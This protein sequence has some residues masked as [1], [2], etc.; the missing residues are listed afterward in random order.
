MAAT[1]KTV[2]L[3]AFA[4]TI[5]QLATGKHA[6]SWKITYRDASGTI[7][8]GGILKLEAKAK[9]KAREIL[10][11]LSGDDLTL[12][13]EEADLIR[14]I[15]EKAV[16]PELLL[17]TVTSLAALKSLTVAA[18]VKTFLEREVEN[19]NY[20]YEQRKDYHRVLGELSTRFGLKNLGIITLEN[21]EKWADA[22][23]CGAKRYNNKRTILLSF[24]RWAVGRN[25]ASKNIAESLPRKRLTR[26]AA[27]EVLSPR[28]FAAILAKCPHNYIPW[29]ALSGF[30]GLRGV[31]IYGRVDDR[32]SGLKWEN[33]DWNRKLIVL[34]RHSA[35]QT[36]S[37]KTRIIPAC[38]ALL[39][40]LEPWQASTGLVFPPSTTLPHSGTNSITSQLAQH[41]PGGKW[42]SNALRASRASYRLAETQ[43]IAIVTLEMG[44]SKDMLLG[45]YLNPRF[46]D[47]AKIWFSLDRSTTS[48][49]RVQP[50]VVSFAV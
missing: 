25:H 38:D 5:T 45:T 40:W 50:E 6:G 9:T 8:T 43:S 22:W 48:Q 13:P 2:K 26:K 39:D 16:K 32:T 4:A 41:L 36:R 10:E 27:H 47:D 30:A 21:L 20:S 28:E 11:S 18:G 33:I 12:T 34:D 29:L 1:K 15:R 7:Q 3:G 49:L 37:S 35:K 19:S 31:E 14:K 46:E 23:K 44:H 17:P 42:K 24:W